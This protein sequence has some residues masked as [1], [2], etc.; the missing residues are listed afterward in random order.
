M[1]QENDEVKFPDGLP[2]G[3][4]PEFVIFSSQNPMIGQPP[5][6]GCWFNAGFPKM[7][8]V[9]LLGKAIESMTMEALA[10][11]ESRLHKVINP[12]AGSVH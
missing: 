11:S 6:V 7:L 10:E 5:N 2:P 9:A 4:K 12:G 1:P 8:L 3:A